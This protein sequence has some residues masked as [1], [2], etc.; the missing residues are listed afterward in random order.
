VW[1]ILFGNADRI[2]GESRDNDKK[3]VS[4]FCLDRQSG[5]PLWE[6][7]SAKEPWWVG[8][9]AVQKNVVLL[10]GYQK[11]DLPGHFGIYAWDLEGAEELWRNEE[12]TFWFCYGNRVY[13]YKTLFERRVGYALELRTGE[14]LETYEEGIED[15]FRVRE[16]A[17][18]EA[19]EDELL[20][21]EVAGEGS[22]PEAQSLVGKETK[23]KEIIGE[24]EYLFQN[25]Y[26]IMNYH[27]PNRNS[28][29]ES[30]KLENHLAIIDSRGGKKVFTDILA[31]EASAP[32]PDSFFVRGGVVFFVKEQKTLLALVLP[33][34]SY[35][36]T[37]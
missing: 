27:L 20:F 17:R 4:F 34:S 24:I 37:E 18:K 25:P 22:P 10:H 30:L 21:P 32:V 9:E 2:V 28:G 8:L 36:E 35:G 5:R 6:D 33:D 31:L 11:P 12:M 16:L 13:T 26:L 15:L 14:V 3:T 29:P 7:R 23:N 19:P 1:R